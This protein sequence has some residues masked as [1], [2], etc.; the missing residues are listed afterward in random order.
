MT[1]TK[2]DPYKEPEY[3][4]RK[5]VWPGAYT[6]RLYVRDIDNIWR[7]FGKK[8]WRAEKFAREH[9]EIHLHGYTERKT[10]T[11]QGEGS[12]AS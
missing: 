3:Q 2:L 12:I 4:I 8:Q 6:Y 9:A 5:V 11:V 1:D 7:R 10:I